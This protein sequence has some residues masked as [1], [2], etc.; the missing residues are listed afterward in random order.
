M[1]RKPDQPFPIVGIGASAGGLEAATALLRHLPT[2][3]GMA[4]VLVQHLDPTHESALTS[5]LARATQMPVGEA[6]HG[7]K[8]EPNQVY[9]I[10]PNKVMVVSKR[11][12]GLSPRTD[13]RETFTAID[14][15]FKSLAEEEG[16]RSIGIILSGSGS[17]GT[18]GLLAIKA[19]GGLTFAQDAKS[20]KYTAMPASAVAAG[21]VDFVLPPEKIGHELSRIAGHPYVAPA[22]KKAERPAL[23]ESKVVEEILTILRQRMG[24]DFTQYKQATLHRRIQRRLVLHKLSSLKDYAAYIRSHTSE[25]KELFTD[26][27]IHVTGFFRDKG[28]FL[29]LKKR[30]F[31]RLIKRKAPGMPIRIW[32]PGCSTGE[33]VY[34]IAIAL[35]EFLGDRKL[36]VPVQMFGTDI[37]EGALEKARAGLYP[38]SIASDVPEDRLRRFFGRT[39]AG[40]RIN[41]TIREMCIFAR[42]NVVTDP[43]FSNIDLISCCNLLIYLGPSLQRKVMPLFHYALRPEGF[44]LLGASET[45]GGFSDLFTLMDKKAKV[46][47][48]KVSH[49]R[50]AVS[51]GF[52]PMPP[53]I[54]T[55]GQPVPTVELLPGI[56][57]IQKQA[58]RIVLKHHT[59]AGVVI[60]RNLEVLQF[61]GQTGLYLEHANG[62][63]SL[64]LLKMAREGLLVGLRAALGR[65]SKLNQPSRAEGVRMKQDGHLTEVAVEVI[66]FQVPPS[67]ERYF[68]VLFESALT[69]PPEP[70]RGGK[71]AAA[72]ERG[73]QSAESREIGRLREELASTRESLQAI[74][75][76]QEATNE[77]L[78]SANEEILSSNEEL[79]STNEE[80]ETAKEELQS[81][82]EELTTLNDEL[83]NRNTELE[84]VSNDMTNL[85]ANVNI[86]VI[87]VSSDHRIRRFTAAAERMFNLIGSDEGRPLS[88]INLKVD[89]PGLD[90]HITEVIES[91][92]TREVEA[93]DREGHWWLV[94]IRPY[95]TLDNKID[96]AVIA[97]LDVNLLK[98]ASLVFRQGRDLAEAVVDTVRQP[99]V[100]LDKDLTV[101]SINQAFCQTF[102]LAPE[103]AVKRKIYEIGDGEWDLPRLR[104]ALEEVL[105][106]NDGVENFAVEHQFSGV[107]RRKLEINARRLSWGEGM[108]EM[109]LLAIADVTEE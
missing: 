95:R 75:E 35:M 65:A 62:E 55:A 109:I 29:T 14:H 42:Q 84:Q 102:K 3:T 8:L 70:V 105:P 80:L 78:R 47:S 52:A 98:T 83:E 86:P 32:V 61:R 60:N 45:V 99:L 11:R 25:V 97:L 46:Y 49:I 69:Q 39:E 72:R 31:P 7:A 67:R 13:S 20:A 41:K 96:G 23:E 2:G 92:Q 48:K 12:L 44:L 82:N 73:G 51:F 4:F 43:P 59:P 71:K 63:A 76:E 90:Q 30:V 89:V 15:F 40:Y 68:L 24:V 93:K 57:D 81:T 107:G 38:E 100:V 56:A 28:A 53:P 103:E 54:T 27:L 64:S 1:K 5:L 34:S 79:Q 104:T 50:S 19:A 108:E 101:K 26:L 58:D 21:C 22:R 94:R 66:P 87:M 33:E 91:L 17:D 37:N 85:L 10:P 36:S 77:E 106:N 9:V 6:R 16:N 74:I 88:D 18:Q